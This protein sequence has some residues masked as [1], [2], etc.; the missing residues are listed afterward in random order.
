MNRTTE[1][2]STEGTEDCCEKKAATGASASTSNAS[3]DHPTWPPFPN[4]TDHEVAKSAFRRV[5][6][7]ST[8]PPPAQSESSL[9]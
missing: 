4:V 1:E 6:Y 7:P 5:P 9:R 2:T 3:P 8:L